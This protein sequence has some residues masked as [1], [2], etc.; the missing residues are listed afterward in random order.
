MDESGALPWR[1]KSLM[2]SGSIRMGWARI[3]SLLLWLMV[4]ILEGVSH[5]IQI[6]RRGAGGP[7]DHL[8]GRSGATKFIRPLWHEA[9]R[10]LL[11][12]AGRLAVGAVG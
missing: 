1:S 6:C 3:S 2:M 11:E 9:E 5:M 10:S 4:T 12:A 7:A 8:R